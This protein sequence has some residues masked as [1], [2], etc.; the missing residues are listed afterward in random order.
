MFQNSSIE[1][2]LVYLKIL[3][4]NSEHSTSF[5]PREVAYGQEKCWNIRKLE[6]FGV[7][8]FDKRKGRFKG[9][10]FRVEGQTERSDQ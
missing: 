3:Q 10:R 9:S 6:G 1:L 8:N 7:L 4:L 2:I 5:I